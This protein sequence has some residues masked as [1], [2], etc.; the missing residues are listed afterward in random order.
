MSPSLLLT[1]FD[2]WKPHHQSNASDDLLEEWLSGRERPDSVHLLRKLPVDFELAPAKVI[3]AIAQLQP[4][5]IVC[6]G[7][8]ERRSRLSVESNGKREH[9]VIHTPVNVR[10]LVKELPFSRISHNAGK[11]VCNHMYYSVLKYLHDSQSNAY[12][13]FVHIPLLS[14]ENRTAIITDFSTILTRLHQWRSHANTIP[15]SC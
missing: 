14:D 4:D 11:F 10:K 3:A 1:S 12:C 9:D 7:M 8:A 15:L 13:I 2:I 6:C 5:I